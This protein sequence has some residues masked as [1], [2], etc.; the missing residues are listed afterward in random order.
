MQSA[1]G[2]LIVDPPQEITHK[3][4]VQPIVVESEDGFY[5][6]TFMGDS[7]SEAY[8]KEQI[9]RVWAQVGIEIEWLEPASY[10]N[11]FAYDGYPIDYYDSGLKRPSTDLLTI[12]TAA[13]SPPRNPNGAVVNLFFVEITPT[14]GWVGVYGAAGS[15][16][17]DRN[18][19]T[20]AIGEELV[21]W[22]GGR[23][24]AASVIAHEIGHNLG[25]DHY[26]LDQ[27]NLLYSG[28]RYASMLY[29]DQRSTILENDPVAVDGYDFLQS[30]SVESGY[31][32][33]ASLNK[34]VEGA[35]GDDDGDKLSNGLEY[36]CGTSPT[37]GNAIPA[38]TSCTS[39]FVWNLSKNPAAV[40][41][42]F[43]F[44]VEGST[45]LSRW[46]PADEVG[47]PVTTLSNTSSNL[48]LLLSSD[49]P[50]AFLH[51]GVVVP[52]AIGADSV[53]FIPLSRVDES[54]QN[55]EGL[56][57]DQGSVLSLLPY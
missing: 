14:Q 28:I 53:K 27:D 38:P 21:T 50:S 35:A 10:A 15:A 51:L 7:A 45:D 42:G 25:L 48:Q 55:A 29:T 43:E 16:I 18:G 13:G 33:W 19:A 52:P 46:I 22:E 39:G 8:M 6:A 56:V 34:V 26:P 2:A 9:N 57:E 20:V 49:R 32:Q 36:L 31:T 40:A 1:V 44:A 24:A 11:D 54:L 41:D 17:L 5:V 30:L 47:S 12:V 4:V 23:D 37:S 3:V